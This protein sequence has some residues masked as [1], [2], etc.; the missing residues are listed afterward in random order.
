MFQVSDN[1]ILYAVWS[2]PETTY[3][4]TYKSGNATVGSD[5][6]TN[7]DGF[8]TM[9]VKSYPS[10][11]SVPEGQEFAY[12]KDANG[13][14]YKVGDSITITE[15]T[16]LEAV[17]VSSPVTYGVTYM[18]ND[19]TNDTFGDVE[20][21]TTI[22][23]S[24]TVDT[25]IVSGTPIRTGYTFVG[26]ATDAGATEKAYSAG[27]SLT[28]SSH[29]TLYAVWSKDP[30][31]WTISY[32]SNDGTEDDV[33]STDTK[34]TTADS[35]TVTFPEEPT[36]DGYVFLGWATKADA[37]EAEV[38]VGE[39][40]ATVS[41]DTDFYAVW[42]ELGHVEIT[43][44]SLVSY[45]GG[46]SQNGGQTP[47][48]RY[49]V[50]L[51]E[52]DTT[53]Y[54]ID[55]A[56]LSVDDLEFT[57]HTIKN[58]VDTTSELN[59]TAAGDG[60]YLFPELGSE[61]DT[62]SDTSVYRSSYIKL[63]DTVEDSETHA[64]VYSVELRTSENAE[65]DSF[66]VT[67]T[68]ADG[69]V[70]LVDIK[71]DDAFVT[72]RQ[73]SDESAIL[74]D[75]SQYLTAVVTDV[76]DAAA[77]IA[78]GKAVAVVDGTTTFTTN[79]DETLGLL[80]T[81]T[82]ENVTGYG[83]QTALAALLF[84]DSIVTT[85]DDNQSAME[86]AAAE[87]TGEDL[88]EWEHVTKYLDIVN[89]NDGNAVLK[90]SDSVTV[91][92]PYPEGVTA[93]DYDFM[94][95]HYEGMER[96]GYDDQSYEMNAKTVDVEATEYGLKFTTDSFSPFTLMWKAKAS[97][98]DPADPDDGATNP[99]DPADPSDGV[100]DPADP[101][102]GAVKPEQ[103]EEGEDVSDDKNGSNAG[104][105]DADSGS[106]TSDALKQPA[107]TVKPASVKK[108]TKLPGTG[109]ATALAQIAGFGTLGLGALAAGLHINRRRNR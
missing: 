97:D 90:A 37:S 22:A 38:A 75:A 27:D 17:F 59:A 33:I 72:V 80:G 109:D 65:W 25:T 93:D 58:G 96:E 31:T 101:V 20:S 104:T 30:V 69:N 79:G 64:G 94:L 63:V 36:R 5:A 86:A 56:T 48:L 53:T 18:M 70:Y 11:A 81:D 1:M 35:E 106:K 44:V 102:D 67:A 55:D 92:W 2:Q 76:S 103:D 23:G 8:A 3:T 60:Y 42:Y 24:T 91:Y 85:G 84:D 32:H 28:V 10:T 50:T 41:G 51:P 26:W 66:Y 87:V 7:S 107:T 47:K 57:I 98:V 62:S 45:V 9:T 6:V 46:I 95:V 73:V 54:D 4:L 77:A 21:V 16:T 52:S 83:D 14:V 89:V 105:S 40:G 39:T 19:G 12:W 13:T 74:D 61:M 34:T 71:T 68:D 29:T 82:V 49:S 88:S 99:A 78:A 15:D 108:S 100:T 43:P